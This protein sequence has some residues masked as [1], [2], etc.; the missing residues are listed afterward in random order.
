LNVLLTTT[1]DFQLF[2]D[3]VEPTLKN[4][5]LRGYTYEEAIQYLINSG[6]RAFDLGH[7][8]ELRLIYGTHAIVSRKKSGRLFVNQILSD[9]YSAYT[10]DYEGGNQYYTLYDHILEDIYYKPYVEFLRNQGYQDLPTRVGAVRGPDGRY[11]ERPVATPYSKLS[12]AE[13][14]HL[15]GVGLKGIARLLSSPAITYTNMDIK[16]IFDNIWRKAFE[17]GGINYG[18]PAL[19]QFFEEN[20]IYPSFSL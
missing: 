15:R 19:R 13:Y 18:L 4:C 6:F 17:M 5:F 11:L 2:C 9:L 8:D 14:L 12:I 20:F 10:H 1:N 7:L 3:L 16:K